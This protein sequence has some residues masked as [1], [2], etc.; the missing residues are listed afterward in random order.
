[1]LDR[2]TA[3][4]LPLA[5]T[6]PSQGDRHRGLRARRDQHGGAG[7]VRGAAGGLG[8]GDPA[9]GGRHEHHLRLH[10][11]GSLAAEPGLELR[12]DRRERPGDDQ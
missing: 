6:H 11:S 3:V 10:H 1:M 2:H 8:G 12:Q 5:E 9:A 4:C 7:R